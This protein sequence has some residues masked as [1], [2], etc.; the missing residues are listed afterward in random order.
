[1]ISAKSGAH[2]R[3]DVSQV[4]RWVSMKPGMTMSPAASMTL[5]PSADEVRPDGG[6]RVALDEHVGLRQLAEGRVLGQDDPVLDEDPVSHGCLLHATTSVTTGG[7]H[8]RAY[9]LPARLLVGATP[10]G[11]DRPVGLSRAAPGRRS[12]SPGRRGRRADA[13]RTRARL[14]PAWG[15]GTPSAAASAVISRR[16]FSA[17][18][19]ENATGVPVRVDERRPLVAHERRAGRARGEDVVGRRAVDAGELG[20]DEALRQRP[21]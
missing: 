6:D 2:V 1:M 7:R 19:S 4:W 10:A 20:Q 9:A 13:V 11:R 16:S 12:R 8:G 18:S 14:A 3:I 15:T 5:A 17:R 21:R